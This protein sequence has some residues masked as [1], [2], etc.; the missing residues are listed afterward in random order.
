MLAH[1]AAFRGTGGKN[2]DK[3]QD[4][5]NSCEAN[6]NAWQFH[7][8]R[9][10]ANSLNAFFLFEQAITTLKTNFY[11]CSELSSKKTFQGENRTKR[12]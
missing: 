12:K 4:V 7:M 6:V 11:L 10:R 5:N 8:T 9:K 3:S 1:D 2:D